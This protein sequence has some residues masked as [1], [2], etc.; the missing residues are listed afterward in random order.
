VE[1]IGRPFLDKLRQKHHT[2]EASIVDQT[3][4]RLERKEYLAGCCWTG[5]LIVH[6]WTSRIIF[7]FPMSGDGHCLDSPRRGKP[8]SETSSCRVLDLTCASSPAE[9][10]IS[11][12]L[13]DLKCRCLQPARFHGLIAQ[14]HECEACS[15]SQT[16]PGCHNLCEQN[17]LNAIDFE[18]EQEWAHSVPCRWFGVS[19][20]HH[21]AMDI[22]VASERGLDW[23]DPAAD[24]SPNG[25]CHFQFC[26]NL[27]SNRRSLLCPC[28]VTNRLH[29]IT[30][31][32]TGTSA[33]GLRRRGQNRRDTFWRSVSQKKMRL[34]N[35]HSECSWSLPFF[36]VNWV[37]LRKSR[38]MYTGDLFRDRLL[39]LAFSFYSTP[40]FWTVMNSIE[41]Q[42]RLSGSINRTLKQIHTNLILSRAIIQVI[43][44]ACEFVIH[45]ILLWMVVYQIVKSPIYVAIIV[46]ID[47]VN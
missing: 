32:S 22:E 20:S 8:H 25:A 12:I 24:F 11:V 28:F 6:V 41:V 5:T 38:I 33:R 19:N 9:H 7:H 14:R 2:G 34:S 44:L 16:C 15:R 1:A 45:S 37:T 39:E 46:L 31:R 13:I 40:S 43:N 26:N 21:T 4:E 27:S 29:W 42:S 10:L 17:V 23:G 36:K 18:R 35:D 47:D 30:V 3:E